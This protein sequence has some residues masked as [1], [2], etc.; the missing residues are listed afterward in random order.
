MIC[1]GNVLAS[2]ERNWPPDNIKLENVCICGYA[3]KCKYRSIWSERQRPINLMMSGSTLAHSRAIAPPARR[4]RA[5]MSDE[6]RPRVGN[7]T[8]A[9]RRR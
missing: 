6:A 4:A 2:M 1:G 3:C 9:A 8:V 5:E 7:N